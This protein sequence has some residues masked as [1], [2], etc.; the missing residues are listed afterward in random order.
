MKTKLLID[1]DGTMFNTKALKIDLF[2]TLEKGG[3]SSDEVLKAYKEE[4]LD[5]QF[6]I[7][8]M[9]RRMKTKKDFSEK[10]ILDNL[11]DLFDECPKFIFEDFKVFLQEVDRH[12]FEVDLFTLGDIGF[13]KRKVENA[14]IVQYFD[15]IYYTD[16][17]KWESLAKI[18]SREET[19]ILIDDRADTIKKVSEEYPNA[20]AICIN[21]KVKDIDDPILKKIEDKGYKNKEINDFSQAFL[22]LN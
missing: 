12:K 3:F 7:D 21:R 8:G 18:V 6:S 13:Q 4:C 19:F 10:E 5:Y 14:G 11:D 1:F 17:Q 20:I 2:K 16:K 22:Y 9:I 15:H